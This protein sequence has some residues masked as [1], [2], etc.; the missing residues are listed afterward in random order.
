MPWFEGVPLNGI[1]C[2]SENMDEGTHTAS[3]E[4]R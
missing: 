2:R 3:G 4:V 1:G